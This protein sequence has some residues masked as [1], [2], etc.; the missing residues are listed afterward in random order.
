LSAIGDANRLA[1]LVGPEG[2]FEAG[3]M[4]QARAAGAQTV[5]LGR[6]I[7]R[8]ETAAVAAT[9]LVMDAFGEMG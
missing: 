6:R 1:L 9:A 5:S 3:E 2:G 4:A 8:M 7:L